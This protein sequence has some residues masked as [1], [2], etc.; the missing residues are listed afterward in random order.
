MQQNDAARAGLT[1]L[2]PPT[3]SLHIHEC[4]PRRSPAPPTA[5]TARRDAAMYPNYFGQT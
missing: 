1:A 5:R 3:G 4:T 2:P